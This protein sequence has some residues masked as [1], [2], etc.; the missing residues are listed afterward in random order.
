M[1]NLLTIILLILCN[2]VITSCDTEVPAIDSTPPTYSFA[3][4]GDN[5]THTFTEKDDPSTF[6]VNMKFNTPYNFTFISYDEGGVVNSEIVLQTEAYLRLTLATDNLSQQ[7]QS[8]NRS[9]LT[10]ELDWF[11]QNGVPKS[12]SFLQGTFTFIP[13]DDDFASFGESRSFY[14][15]INDFGGENHNFNETFNSIPFYIASDN[16]VSEIIN[17]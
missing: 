9:F 6:Q 5:F 11:H 14:I 7:W 13:T 2:V 1:K 3:I 17:Y 16:E 15:R 12:G 4:S 10:R 8:S